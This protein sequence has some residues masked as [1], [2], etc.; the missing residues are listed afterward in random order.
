MKNNILKQI[1]SKLAK[2]SLLFFLFTNLMYA[3]ETGSS[4]TINGVVVDEQGEALIGVG[5]HLKDRPGTGWGTDASGK[6]S[7]KVSVGDIL[8]F[9]YVGFDRVE[10]I[11]TKPVSELKITMKMASHQLEEMVVLGMGSQRKVSVVG[12][13]TSVNVDE[14]QVPATSIN[15]MLGGRIPGI[16][17]LQTSGEPGKN[18][19]EF[20]VRGISTFGASSGAL[21]LIDGLEGTLSQVDPADIESFLS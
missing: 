1:A 20:W 4:F 7:V 19:S 18:I 5:I 21:V 3:Q 9:T 11:I 2:I 10:H 13:I 12:A 17:S 6:F 15:N 14:L 8:V 16:I